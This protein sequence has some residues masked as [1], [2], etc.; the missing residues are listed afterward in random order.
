MNQS[1][2]IHTNS[3]HMQCVLH[4]RDVTLRLVTGK[5]ITRAHCV[6]GDPH[7]WIKSKEGHRWEHT[8]VE[9]EKVAE[10]ATHFIFQVTFTPKNY[11]VKYHFI[12]C[13]EHECIQF[14]EDGFTPMSEEVGLWNNF[15]IPYVHASLAVNSPSWVKD[16]IWYQIFPDRFNNGNPSNDRQETVDWVNGPVKNNVSFGGDLKGITQKLDY[17]KNLGF[18]GIYLTPIFASPTAH[19]YDTIDYFEIDPWFGSKEDLKTLVSEAH[20]RGIKL[21]LDAVFNHTGRH[22]FAFEDVLKHK[23][24]S[25]YKDWFHITSFEPFEYETFASAK[26]MPKINMLNKE[27]RDY[28]VSVATYWVKE[29]NIDGWRFDVANEIDMAF[30]KEVH[31]QTRAINPNLYLLGEIWHDAT[32]WL[33][34]DVFDGVMNYPTGRAILDFSHGDIDALTFT[35]RYLKTQNSV[36]PNILENMFTLLDSHD[37]PRLVHLL[38]HEELK[39]KLALTLLYLSPGS[40]CVYYGSETLLE[41]AHDPDNRRP[42]P[43]HALNH[44][45]IE[46]MT[47][48]ATIRKFYPTITHAQAF[49]FVFENNLLKLR[50]KHEPIECWINIQSKPTFVNVD[51]LITQSYVISL[52]PFGAVITQV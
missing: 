11:R 26:N 34:N 30:L 39:V 22:F 36:H 45:F 43:W 40:I 15:F 46:F 33:N 3:S 5:D 41:G 32:P 4:N 49:D 10:T 48:L 14:G 17:L 35:Q 51:D 29:F 21:M 16:T 42:M 12:V 47:N 50:Y 52:P 8:V 25:Q 7:M 9:M 20:A 27:A 37:T 44:D 28:F 18:N 38:S 2:I 1:A 19:K 24:K 23:E 31:T 6:H 13:D